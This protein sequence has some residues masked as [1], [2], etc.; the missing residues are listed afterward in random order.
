MRTV[1]I[2]EIVALRNENGSY[3]RPDEAS[4]EVVIVALRNENGSYNVFIHDAR[5]FLIVALRNENG[6]YNSNTRAKLW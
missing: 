1:Q 2:H 4:K 6:S 3:N 5:R